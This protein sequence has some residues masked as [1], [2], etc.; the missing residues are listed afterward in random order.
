[1]SDSPIPSIVPLCLY[2]AD[3]NHR[4]YINYPSPVREG[5]TTKFVCQEHPGM[6][7]VTT[8]YVVNPDFRPIPQDMQMFCITSTDIH[9]LNVQTVYDI[10]NKDL[11]NCIRFIAWT[12]PVPYTT[13][14]SF[15]RRE[16]GEIYVNILGT[17]EIIENELISIY[18]LLDHRN[19]FPRVG[20]DL[21][22]FPIINNVPQFLFSR[23]D[24][25]CLPDPKGVPLENCEVEYVLNTEKNIRPSL[26]R[27]LESRYGD[28]NRISS[29]MYII[30]TL[31]FLGLIT[32][33]IIK[34]S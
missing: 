16:D 33:I 19:G 18:V 32:Y 30:L 7:L 4:N 34:E 28:K 26:L 22:K 11:P 15:A 23:Q 20:N 9:T 24:V 17:A 10:F 12:K 2:S 3:N 31:I 14:L 6:D 1:M 21:G 25:R 8:F 27:Y 13:R 5:N 29:G